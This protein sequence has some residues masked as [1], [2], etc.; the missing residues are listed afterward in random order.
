LAV[1][2]DEELLRRAGPQIIGAAR[3]VDD[4][5]I[6]VRSEADATAVLSNLREALYEYELHVNDLKTSIVSGVRPLDDP[7]A[8][9]LRSASEQLAA[10][11]SEERIAGFLNEAVSL[12]M[13][14]KTQ[15]PLKLAVRRA[16][17]YRLYRSPYFEMI[18]NHLQR[19]VYHFPHAIDYICL[20]IAKRFAVGGGIDRQGWTEII[21]MEVMRHLILG[22]HHEACWLFWLAIVC[23]LTI[24]RRIIDEMPKHTNQ[25]LLAMAAAASVLGKCDR[26]RI[27]FSNRIASDADTWLVNLV[28]RAVGFTRAQFGGCFADECEHLAKKQIK[29]IDFQA[30]L[31]RVAAED[32]SAISNVRFGYEDEDGDEDDD[33]YDA[34]FDIEEFQ[35]RLDRD[36][37]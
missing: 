37:S 8:S 14:L 9:R 13:E 15:S 12:S 3:H 19:M 6:G 34:D 21:N 22:H 4:F 36:N 16:D 5:Y 20:F 23:D 28:S 24:D 17:R 2:V 33:E 7:W 18:E 32:V 30:H 26:P 10:D 35:R 29:L 1:R 31:A 27:R 11:K 25:H